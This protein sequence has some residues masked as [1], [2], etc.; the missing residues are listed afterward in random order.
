VTGKSGNDGAHAIV[1]QPAQ[2]VPGKTARPTQMKTLY[3]DSSVWHA[4]CDQAVDPQQLA[5]RLSSNDVVLGFG[6]QDIY[7]I[8]RAL[9]SRDPKSVT[10]GRKLFN[11]VYSFRAVSMPFAKETKVLLTDEGLDSRLLDA[12]R[13]HLETNEVAEI[14]M[15]EIS[16]LRKG[17]VDAQQQAH[18][19]QRLRT[20][21]TVRKNIKSVYEK[22]SEMRKLL[23]SVKAG[24]LREFID[25][26]LDGRMGRRILRERLRRVFPSFPSDQLTLLALD[27]LKKPKYRVSHAVTRAYIYLNWR[28]AN[29]GS[30][31]EDV[32]DDVY[33]VVNAAY[34]DYFAT[35]DPDQ[36]RYATLIVP[37]ISVVVTQD[38]KP[39]FDQLLA[40]TNG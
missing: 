4:L 10:A 9:C 33:H 30:I 12:Q 37:G 29:R 8:A 39:I 11:Y 19:D 31:R 17:S 22:H 27:I 32:Y 13:T 25:R 6:V 1:T 3:A 5:A 38:E 18:I 36:A 26:Q 2:A 21:S 28:C 24:R 40:G 35:T 7:E 15:E 20:K 23:K 16:T 14:Y 34:F